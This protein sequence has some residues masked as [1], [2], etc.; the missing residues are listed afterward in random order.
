VENWRLCSI[1]LQIFWRPCQVVHELCHNLIKSK[2]KPKKKIE[3]LGLFIEEEYWA[4]KI[5][6][7]KENV[8]S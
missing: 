2:E 8:K 7:L 5:Q 6:D 1:S 3:S 4:W